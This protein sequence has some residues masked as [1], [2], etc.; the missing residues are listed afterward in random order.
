MSGFFCGSG[1]CLFY[2]SI[3]NIIAISEKLMNV[4]RKSQ[5]NCS[6]LVLSQF[7]KRLKH[8]VSQKKVWFRISFSGKRYVSHI[9]NHFEDTIIYSFFYQ[10]YFYQNKKS[11][12]TSPCPY[13]E[14]CWRKLLK[15][16]SEIQRRNM[17]TRLVSSFASGIYL[18]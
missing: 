7:F 2:I 5:G 8:V 6:L 18:F 10:L 17:E 15:K 14:N 12:S 3:L 1:F 4:I 11:W 9:Y 13:M 16:A